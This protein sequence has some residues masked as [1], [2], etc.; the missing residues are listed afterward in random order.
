MQHPCGYIVLVPT[1]H[2][3]LAQSSAAFFTLALELMIGLEPTTCTLRM[4]CTTLV[5]HKHK[6]KQI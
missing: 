4:C 6:C 1:D 5:L 3:F 2:E